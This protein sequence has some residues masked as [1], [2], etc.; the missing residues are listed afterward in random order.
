M[1]F[2]VSLLFQVKNEAETQLLKAET[3]IS[4]GELETFV[5]LFLQL[6]T[7]FFFKVLESNTQTA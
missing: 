2:E 5:Q 3:S 6:L 4:T 7:M 1:N